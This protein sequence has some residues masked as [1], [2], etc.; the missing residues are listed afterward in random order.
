LQQL[1]AEA[2]STDLDL[3]KRWTAES[4]AFEKL[5]AQIARLQIQKSKAETAV[6]KEQKSA[7]EITREK[8]RALRAMQQ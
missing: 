5:N 7:R 8:I 2:E 3:L 4:S 1:L 6:P